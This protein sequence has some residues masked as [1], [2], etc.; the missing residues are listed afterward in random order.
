MRVTANR[1]VYDS[2]LKWVNYEWV[3]YEW[4]MMRY[5]TRT[6]M[7]STQNQARNDGD[8]IVIMNLDMYVFSR[9]LGC[10]KITIMY[11]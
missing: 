7:I 5:M 1:G 10:V 4:V 9:P 3:N 2:C 8:K 6:Q 11:H